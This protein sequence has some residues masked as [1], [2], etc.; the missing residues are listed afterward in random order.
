MLTRRNH[1]GALS[2]PTSAASA[3]LENPHKL[4]PL[5]FGQELRHLGN[6]LHLVLDAHGNRL[7]NQGEM[8]GSISARLGHIIHLDPKP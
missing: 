5:R 7:R 6:V 1:E 4:I 8:S 2:V 3:G